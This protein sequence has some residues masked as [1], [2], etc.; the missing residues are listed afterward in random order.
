M[1]TRIKQTRMIT[2]HKSTIAWISS[3]LLFI[4]IS[5][6]CSQPDPNLP[7]VERNDEVKE[8]FVLLDTLVAEYC[9]MVEDVV[10][11]TSAMSTINDED[12]SFT[13]GLAILTRMGKSAFKISKLA[14]EVEVLEEKHPHFEKEL[15]EDDFEEFMGIFT[16]SI[17]RF[18][19][20][21]KKLEEH[22]KN[23]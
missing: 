6:G 11:G 16:K 22:E 5:V 23:K 13:E 2:L 4:F 14:K 8:Y 18:Y 3:F 1:N 19:D 20:L 10:E 7:L 21:G 15:T 12:A 17:Q 9:M